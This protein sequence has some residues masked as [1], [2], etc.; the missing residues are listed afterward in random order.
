MAF[1]VYVGPLTLYYAGQWENAGQRYARER[2]ATYHM[3]RTEGSDDRVTDPEMLR[4]ALVQWRHL[5]SEALGSNIPEPLDWDETSSEYATGRPNW[6]GF[7]SLRLWAAYAEHPD[8]TL[9]LRCGELEEDPAYLRST[10]K[11]AGA[12][13]FPHL[14]RSLEFWL[15]SPFD[16]TFKAE[17]PNGSPVDFGSAMTLLE[18]LRDLN[19]VTWKADQATI[20]T[21]GMV[22]PHPEA[23]FEQAAK[24]GFSTMLTLAQYACEKRMPMKLDY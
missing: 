16:F 23:P 4:P 9:P 13:R 10:A 15:P 24:Y 17:A 12:S 14:I 19:D 11:T 7:A 1:D 21:W 3:I 22:S 20:A 5:L 6:D 8:L 2:G 18:H